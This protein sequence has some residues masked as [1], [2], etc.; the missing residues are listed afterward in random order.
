MSASTMSTSSSNSEPTRKAW[1][2]VKTTGQM[3]KD[4][5]SSFLEANLG[6]YKK[7][8][9]TEP[10]CILQKNTKTFSVVMGIPEDVLF[11]DTYIGT[12][13]TACQFKGV[14]ITLGH[15]WNVE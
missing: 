9:A 15:W 13:L 2:S 12:F 14:S 1:F 7:S 3:T 8:V 11:V 10:S 4:G 6:K 5:L